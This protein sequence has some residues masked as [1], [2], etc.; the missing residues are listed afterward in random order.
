MFLAKPD[1][2]TDDHKQVSCH[3]IKKHQA[4]LKNAHSGVPQPLN[5]QTEMKS[6]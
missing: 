1:T 3:K 5:L 6:K 2:R 4:Y